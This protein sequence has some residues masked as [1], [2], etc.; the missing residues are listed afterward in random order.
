MNR[1]WLLCVVVLAL[2]LVS[3]IGTQTALAQDT[4]V[5]FQ[6]NM[7]LKMLEGT[8]RPLSGDIVT[9]RGDFNNWGNTANTDTLK[10]ANADS[11]YTLTKK[12]PVG[13]ITYKFWK[14]YRLGDY[15]ND[16]SRTYTVVAGPNVLPV[17]PF[18][19]DTVAG[20][21]VPVQFKVNMRVKILEQTFRPDLGDQVYLTGNFISSDWGKARDT[22]VGGT[23]SIYTSATLTLPTG[24]KASYKFLKTV[25]GGSDWEGDPNRAF[26]VPVGGGTPAPVPLFDRDSV[27]N[28]NIVG[29]LLFNVNMA[30]FEQLGWFDETKGDTM[31]VRG[32]AFGW[33]ASAPKMQQNIFKPEVWEVAQPYL[34]PV[35]STMEYKFFMIMDSIRATANF[36]GY[37][38]DM[39]GVRYEHPAETGDGNR[40][41]D[42]GST[43]GDKVGPPNWFSS[44]DP[45]GLLLH[46]TDSVN[47]TLR[48]NMFPAKANSNPFNPTTDTVKLVISGSPLWRFSQVKSQGAFASQWIMT[49]GGLTDSIYSVTFKVKGKTHYNIMYHFRYNKSDGTSVEQTGGLGATNPNI[50]RFIQPTG[51][52]LFPSS[53]TAPVDVWKSTSPFFAEDPPFPTGVKANGKVPEGYSLAQNYPNPFNPSTRIVYTLPEK[54]NVSLKVFNVLGQEVETLF[55]GELTKGTYVSVFEAKRF[56]SG[57]YFYRLETGSFTSVKKMLLLK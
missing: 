44:I 34:L 13:G 23:D 1:T 5:T 35:G 16:P 14:T 46:T 51:A 57:V 33:D 11:I 54:A 17:V 52:N 19:R 10:D 2:F 22:L 25:R 26:T 49:R 42:L 39:D 41:Y 50:S 43:G 6:V 24:Y 4:T 45:R 37:K 15:E 8:F 21:P 28:P 30:P 29:R 18:N 3:G 12:L 48:V 40:K 36:P 38:D 32:G 47:V 20:A 31:Q 53:Y 27:V 55:N 56:A 9:V 7:N